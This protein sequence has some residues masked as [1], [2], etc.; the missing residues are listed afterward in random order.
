[1]EEA[2]KK[3]KEKLDK[4]EDSVDA[5]KGLESDELALLKKEKIRMQRGFD[6]LQDGKATL[7]AE[8][9]ALKFKY[10]GLRTMNRGLE[11]ERRKQ[12][13]RRMLSPSARSVSVLSDSGMSDLG[14]VP[15][16]LGSM[17]RSEGRSSTGKRKR[18][19]SSQKAS[20]GSVWRTYIDEVSD[21]LKGMRP[22]QEYHPVRSSV[23]LFAA[24][25]MSCG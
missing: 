21:L 17:S 5:S 10:D 7:D 11:E 16:T 12:S 3:A 13:V 14:M 18:T 4:L 2:L 8:Y 24:W 1:L 6:D 23:S 15:I 20:A 9:E 25:G 22:V 19:D